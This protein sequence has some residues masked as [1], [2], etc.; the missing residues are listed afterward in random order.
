MAKTKDKQKLDKQKIMGLDNETLAIITAIIKSSNRE[1]I[2]SDLILQAGRLA[3]VVDR[4]KFWIVFN[5]MVDSE[6]NSL[7]RRIRAVYREL[8][9]A[10]L[11]GNQLRPAYIRL[12]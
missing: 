12:N 9:N 10:V 4:E 3:D 8:G 1:V 6:D 7:V 2:T 11:D 5:E